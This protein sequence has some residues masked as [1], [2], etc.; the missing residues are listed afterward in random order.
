MSRNTQTPVEIFMRPMRK[1][2][3]PG[4]VVF[5]PFSGSGSQLSAAEQLERRCR[6]I[7]LSPAFVDVGIRRWEKATK[8][9]AI[10]SAPARR[11]RRSRLN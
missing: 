6:A 7:E 2:T 11:S 3:K 1:R 8:K 10:L 4:D 5:E 9:Q